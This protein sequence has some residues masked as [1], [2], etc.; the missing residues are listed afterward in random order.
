M[1]RVVM[2][3][4]RSSEHPSEAISGPVALLENK[5]EGG[6]HTLSSSTESRFGQEGMI[7]ASRRP[8]SRLPCN[9]ALISTEKR[10]PSM[11]RVPFLH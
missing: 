7:R 9:Q 3:T 4:P 2:A 1:L 5:V 10:S 11:C 6:I 8:A